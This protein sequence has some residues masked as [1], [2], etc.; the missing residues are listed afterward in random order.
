MVAVSGL[1][2]D[3]GS[4]ALALVSAILFLAVAARL[5]VRRQRERAG[6]EKSTQD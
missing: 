2:S 4:A 1:L 6:R 3:I 5:V